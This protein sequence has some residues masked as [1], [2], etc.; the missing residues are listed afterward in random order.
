MD[1]WEA[2][3]EDSEALDK[4]I[5]TNVNLLKHAD[6][7][8]VSALPAAAP[9]VAPK[10]KQPKKVV[11]EEFDKK[12]KVKT[13]P[14]QS[15]G[16]VDPLSEKAR[17]QKLVEEADHALA[18]ELFDDV[19]KVTL[20]TEDSYRQYAQQ[21]A[22]HLGSGPHHRIP[23][24][25]K[26]LLRGC[27]VH[28]TSAHLTDVSQTLTALITEKQKA[29]KGPEKKKKT[30]TKVSIKGIGKNGTAQD[31]GSDEDFIDQDDEYGDFM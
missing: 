2:L 9:V 17:L 1:D 18:D 8:K 26:E 6:E 11:G 25:L 3:A 20:S 13:K 28:L 30:N 16:P 22:G 31:F 15:E 4:V 27:A 10:P 12:Q 7:D 14:A 19:P 21:V 24:F 29:E 23:A 5:S